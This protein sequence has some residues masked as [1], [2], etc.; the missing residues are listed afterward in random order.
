MVS[1]QQFDRADKVMNASYVLR[2]LM[3]LNQADL[4]VHID[5]RPSLLSTALSSRHLESSAN[6]LK[7]AERC[8]ETETCRILQVHP[9]TRDFPSVETII[10]YFLKFFFCP[11]V[12]VLNQFIQSNDKGSPFVLQILGLALGFAGRAF[13]T[14]PDCATI[15][16]LIYEWQEL[17]PVETPQPLAV[18]TDPAREQFYHVW[19]DMDAFH[20][21]EHA[22]LHNCLP[23][24]LCHF[25]HLV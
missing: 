20:V 13:K 7:I 11:Y 10:R 9:F 18:Q 12:K 17:L 15:F 4:V 25:S 1:G 2:D 8:D 14:F 21:V 3:E 5:V 6:V 19:K 22:L 24:G 16:N 23:L